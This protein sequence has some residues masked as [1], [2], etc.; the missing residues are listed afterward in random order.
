MKLYRVQY[1]VVKHEYYTAFVHAEDRD[2]A[3]T[4]VRY[5]DVQSERLMY[6]DSDDPTDIEVYLVEDQE[7]DLAELK[8]RA[9]NL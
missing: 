8:S 4:R 7:E 1:K 3:E 6:D 5:G 9:I 2:E